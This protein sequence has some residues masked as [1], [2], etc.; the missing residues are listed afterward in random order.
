MRRGWGAS[1]IGAC[2]FMM[3]SVML[4]SAWAGSAVAD[5][6]E[7]TLKAA[8][9]DVDAGRCEQAAARLEP[10][11][12]L[13]NRAR[14]LGGLCLIKTGRYPEA[15]RSRAPRARSRFASASG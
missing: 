10:I 6:V 8:K 5:P 3:A 9:A 7:D 15:V 12:G 2:V 4:T 1:T 13:Q 11:E 14:L